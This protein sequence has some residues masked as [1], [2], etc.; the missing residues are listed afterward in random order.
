MT[1]EQ[2]KDL[3]LDEQTKLL[4]TLA[5]QIPAI[6]VQKNEEAVLPREIDL[7]GY[8]KLYV[9]SILYRRDAANKSFQLAQIEFKACEQMQQ[10]LIG[11]LVTKHG[12]NTE[13]QDIHIDAARKVVVVQSKVT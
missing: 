10:Q 3:P 11:S 12:V 9:D 4:Q 2:I 1:P 6:Q 13:S 8:E 7:D 5:Q